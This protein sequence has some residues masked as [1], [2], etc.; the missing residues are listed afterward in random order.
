[1]LCGEGGGVVEEAQRGEGGE[2]DLAEGVVGEEAE[3]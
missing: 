1:V 3:A 2:A